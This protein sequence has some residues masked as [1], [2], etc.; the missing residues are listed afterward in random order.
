MPATERTRQYL[1]EHGFDV[2]PITPGTKRCEATGWPERPAM[3]LW[4][5][6]QGHDVG[7][8]TGRVIRRQ[9][10]L[11]T[12]AVLDADDKTLPGSSAR[13][14]AALRRMGIDE[15]ET[16]EVETRNGGTH[17]YIL[18]RN[19]PPG[20]VKQFDEAQGIAGELRHGRG[21]YVVAPPSPGY[22]RIA[23]DWRALATI[24]YHDI[25]PL[26][27][28]ATGAQERPSGAIGASAGA[29]LA[30]ALQSAHEG[31]RNDTGFALACQCRDNGIDEGEAVAVLLAYQKHCPQ[32]HHPYT[33]SEALASL[34]QAYKRPARDPWKGGDT[35]SIYAALDEPGRFVGRTAEVDRDVLKAHCTHYAAAR[36]R[37]LMYHA[38]NRELAEKAGITHRTAARATYRL[39][40]D[41]WLE[42]VKHA[43]GV[44]AAKYA[45]GVKLLDLMACA[46]LPTRNTQVFIGGA[47]GEP[48]KSIT[49]EPEPR[50]AGHS[51]DIWR[52]GA[53]GK[54]ARRVYALL[55]AGVTDL[56]A[57]ADAAGHV[58]STIKRAL[59]RLE[60]WGLIAFDGSIWRVRAFDWPELAA[61]LGIAGYSERQREQ[62]E[63]E[64]LRFRGLVGRYGLGRLAKRTLASLTI[65]DAVQK[66]V[67][68]VL[69]FI[70]PPARPAPKTPM[71]ARFVGDS[72][73]ICYDIV[74]QCTN[75][76]VTLGA[77]DHA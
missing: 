10:H 44:L 24:N 46:N 77:F 40:A 4:K 70:N 36:H 28:P 13:L 67:Q 32:G 52:F 12:T 37:G 66:T 33:T 30:K 69:D 50:D 5:N 25:A 20:N 26:L 3:A 42:L 9:G 72:P 60:K 34:R 23:G 65:P 55:G 47:E 43:S 75:P 76:A 48:T 49:R 8:R 71:P 38:S 18:L 54:A 35:P 1:T 7:I 73:P 21:A 41:G 29:I 19:A 6:R 57:L 62:H 64:R 17:F 61:R 74:K 27:E 51:A 22:T 11:Y 39:I 58:K 63:R 14:R 68:A 45:P 15:G 59:A 2:I 53:L 31:N 16:V 56:D